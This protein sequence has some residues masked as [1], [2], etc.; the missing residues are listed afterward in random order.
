MST[1]RFRFGGVKGCGKKSC[2]CTKYFCS[3]RGYKIAN[4][5]AGT[6]AAVPA[7]HCGKH[8]RG[9]HVMCWL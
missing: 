3:C 8:R 4:F 5:G 6:A 1:R 9:C 2:N 7:R